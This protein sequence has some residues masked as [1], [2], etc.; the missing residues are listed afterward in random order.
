MSRYNFMYF[1]TYFDNFSPIF[2]F[3]KFQCQSIL[4]AFREIQH[5]GPENLKKSSQKNSWNQINQN[6]FFR[7]IA[8]LAVLNFFPSSKIDF[9]PCLKLQKME[10]GEKIFCE[11]DLS[12]FMSFFG[13]DFFKFS[14]P[15]WATY[16]D[17]FQVLPYKITRSSRKKSLLGTRV[18]S[19]MFFFKKLKSIE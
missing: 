17:F 2:F 6:L 12:D 15:L 14:G 11:I 10:F 3:K 7:E 9:W 13:L 18:A 4:Q 1:P 19:S 5:S 8:F 16:M